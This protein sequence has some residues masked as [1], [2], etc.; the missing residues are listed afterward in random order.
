MTYIV[1][2]GALNSVLSY[3]LTSHRRQYMRWCLQSSYRLYV[4]GILYVYYLGT[5]ETREWKT[6]HR[7]TQDETGQIRAA[8]KR[9]ATNAETCKRGTGN[10]GIKIYGKRWRDKRT[11]PKKSSKA[12]S[13]ASIQLKMLTWWCDVTRVPFSETVTPSRVC[14]YSANH[15]NVHLIIAMMTQ[16]DILNL[17]R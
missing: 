5:P 10:A 9:G 7:K 12:E 15:S 1:S 14:H 13:V 4:R 3:F 6:R 2:G 8:G 17:P 11:N 16:S